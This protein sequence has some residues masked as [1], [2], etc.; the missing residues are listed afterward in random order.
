M[1]IISNL[2]P[3]LETGGI[4]YMAGSQ[5]SGKLSDAKVAR[6]DTGEVEISWKLEDL[7]GISQVKFT[8]H[9]I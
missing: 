8:A 2:H 9:L 7:S 4:S 1:L 5:P 3:D 6:N